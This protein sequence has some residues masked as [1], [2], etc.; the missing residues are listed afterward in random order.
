MAMEVEDWIGPALLPLVRVA[1]NS[2]RTLF[3]WGSIDDMQKEGAVKPA[4]WLLSIRSWLA[5]P[6][7]LPIFEVEAFRAEE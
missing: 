7:L 6:F 4:R 1:R 3:S 5:S 2:R